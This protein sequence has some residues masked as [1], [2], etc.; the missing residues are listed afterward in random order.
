[1]YKAAK[2][3]SAQ[4]W[5]QFLVIDGF[6]Q[7]WDAASVM[8]RGVVSLNNVGMD[9][10]IQPHIKFRVFETLAACKNP[11]KISCCLSRSWWTAY[12]KMG[13]VLP[14]VLSRFDLGL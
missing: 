5:I 12:G 14:C 4:D 6:Q 1:M 3:V 7:V 13:T 2:I 11:S 9:G 8:T 10:S